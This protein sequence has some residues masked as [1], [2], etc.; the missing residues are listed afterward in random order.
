MDQLKREEV[1]L[2][3]AANFCGLQQAFDSRARSACM[4]R[5]FVQPCKG[6]PENLRSPDVRRHHDAVVHPLALPPCSHDSGVTQVSKVTGDLRLGL[7][8]DL[9]EIAD[10]NLLIA[11]EIQEPEAGIVT[12]GPEKNVPR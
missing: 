1:R 11:H 4:A 3:S 10:T 5:L 2:A 8:E 9:D 6:L 7:I 12:R